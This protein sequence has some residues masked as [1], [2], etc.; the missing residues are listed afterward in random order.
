MDKQKRSNN[1]SHNDLNESSS[2]STLPTI[3]LKKLEARCEKLKRMVQKK[4]S[5]CSRLEKISA[6]G[7]FYPE[8]VHKLKNSLMGISGYAELAGL[9][10][11]RDDIL[12][13]I[14]KI[15]PL[16][17]NISNLLGQFRT[18]IHPD[19]DSYRKFDLNTNITETM[20]ILDLIKP[21]IFDLSTTYSKS[22]LFIVGDAQQIQQVHLNVAK[23]FFKS[24]PHD[25]NL[26][27]ETETQRI[28]INDWSD[29]GFNDL[30]QC[31]P[32]G[33]WLKRLQNTNQLAIISYRSAAIEISQETILDLF[34]NNQKSILDHT[35]QI[36]F[37]IIVDIVTRHNG[38]F[39]VASENNA[40]TFY[41]ALPLV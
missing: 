26:L 34:E 28:D 30:V 5:L 32:A 41:L 22:D 8:I 17:S 27:I 35:T 2:K 3:E 21:K 13:Q 37:L 12:L 1:Y 39:L 36:S 14:N 10:Q 31:Q 4:D 33:S 23:I 29:R 7:Q 18:M 11:S 38:N 9:A 25:Q 20:M 6:A 19:E 40:T 15:P 24:I 16:V